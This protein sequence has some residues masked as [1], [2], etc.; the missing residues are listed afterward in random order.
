MTLL[1]LLHADKKILEVSIVKSSFGLQSFN[2]FVKTTGSHSVPLFQQI[3]SQTNMLQHESLVQ[4][5]VQESSMQLQ[6]QPLI[7]IEMNKNIV[8]GVSSLL[9][10]PE[11]YEMGR[12]L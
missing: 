11:P 8:W 1:C 10:C 6:N 4:F 5:Q 3:L 12:N 7:I 9:F 2:I